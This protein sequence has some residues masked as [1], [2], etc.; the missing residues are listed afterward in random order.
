MTKGSAAICELSIP[1]S[2]GAM[3]EELQSDGWFVENPN[4][5]TV[6]L[7]R[8]N[9]DNWEV[10]P[11]NFSVPMFERRVREEKQCLLMIW[12][13]PSESIP[14]SFSMTATEDAW[15]VECDHH[16]MDPEG[17]VY[18]DRWILRRARALSRRSAVRG[19]LL[20]HSGVTEWFDWREWFEISCPAMPRGAVTVGVPASVPLTWLL[21]P[22]GTEILGDFAIYHRGSAPMRLSPP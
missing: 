7:W 22:Q 5:G 10:D 6:S 4:L 14:L 11:G 13:S 12:R 8:A 16:D 20:D 19:L 17:I 21:E 3:L 9:G 2:I 15:W 1:N 18:A